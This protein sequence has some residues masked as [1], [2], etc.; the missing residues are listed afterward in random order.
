MG[1]NKFLAGF[2][3]FLL[4]LMPWSTG[5]YNAHARYAF[6]K[7][8]AWSKI[9]SCVENNDTAAIVSMAS[10][11]LKSS[12]ADLSD[13]VSQLINL[14]DRDY[15]RITNSTAGT[16]QDS[17]IYG[18]E[19]VLSFVYADSLRTLVVDYDVTN[20][21]NKYDVGISRMQL[22]KGRYADPDF[23]VLADIRI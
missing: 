8:A 13:Q 10:P 3:A 21:K 11:L 18:V 17:G 20:S 1:M 23:A 12:I 19:L 9:V 4:W 15:T 16:Y 22:F 14:I 2:F 6:D 7:D 5:I